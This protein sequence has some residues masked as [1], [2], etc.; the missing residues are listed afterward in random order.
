MT[1]ARPSIPHQ[2]RVE[3]IERSSTS[4]FC[5]DSFYFIIAATALASGMAPGSA[6][7]YR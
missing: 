7:S 1:R 3:A 6:F 4:A 2:H 5:K